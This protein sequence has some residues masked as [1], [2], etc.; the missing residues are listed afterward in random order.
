MSRPPAPS[1]IVHTVARLF[2]LDAADV[3]TRK[4]SRAIYDAKAAICGLARD[5]L[6]HYG[7]PDIAKLVVGRHSAHATVYGAERRWAAA[8]M[9]HRFSNGMTKASII[10]AVNAAR[11]CPSNWN[12]LP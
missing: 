12:R 1:T 11:D 6:P 3:M 8:S 2:G 7:Y 5:M 9:Q 4:R 10:A